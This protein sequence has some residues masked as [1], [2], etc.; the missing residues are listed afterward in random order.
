MA[1]APRALPEHLPRDGPPADTAAMHA[2]VVVLASLISFPGLAR[3]GVDC[4][5]GSS[6]LADQRALA[7]LRTATGAACP[8]ASFT[9]ASAYRRCARGV[10]ESAATAGTL[11]RECKAT[12]NRTYKTATC[13]G[14]QVGC[15]RFAPSAR[16]PLSCRLKA[17]DRCHDRSGFT[18]HAC[19]NETHCADVVDW[20]AS[21][22][23]DVRRSGPFA[24]GMRTITF[25]KPS[26]LDPNQTRVL[27]TLVWYPAPA[28]SGPVDATYKAVINAPLDPGAGPYPLVMFS[29]GSCGLPN[30]S[31]FLWPLIA[32]QGFVVVAPPHPGNTIFEFPT[33][34][35]LQAQVASAVERPA[36]I[37][38]VLDQMLAADLD[39]ASPFAGAIDE[40]RIGMAGHS[41]GGYTTYVVAIQDARIKVALPMAPAVPASQPVLTVPSLT[42]LSQLDTFVNLTAIRDAYQRAHPAKYLVEIENAG[43]FAYSTG[44]FPSPDCNPP[45]TLT[46]DEAHAAVLRWV[47][48]FLKVYL[49]GD[50]SYASF[51]AQPAPPGFVLQSSP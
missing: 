8:C 4:L 30:Q 37:R 9:A 41:F 15:G 40:T 10:V 31:S 21:T 13:G 43:H 27:D 12:A 34:G 24:A 46:Q 44:C 3:A 23:T 29:H 20:T 19:S 35:T 32:S 42:M 26:V 22:C 47:L 6:V 51:L 45:T 33:C 16:T 50:A 25:T 28:G 2:T 48:G 1:S 49:A 36:D 39:P 14:S 17:A 18:E 7:D 38:F 11:R 5:T